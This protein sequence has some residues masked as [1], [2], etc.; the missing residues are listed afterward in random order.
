[1][2]QAKYLI[3]STLFIL[4][5]CGY[6]QTTTALSSAPIS[7]ALVKNDENGL[8]RGQLAQKMGETNKFR[9]SSS[10]NAKYELLIDVSGDRIETVGH[11]KGVGKSLGKLVP[12]EGNRFITAKVKVL[13][14][15]SGKEVVAPFVVTASVDF[16]FITPSSEEDIY[17]KI[18]NG[19]KI[20]T[21]KYSYGQL[22]AKET[23]EK[24]CQEPLFDRLSSQI[25]SALSRANINA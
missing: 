13:E 24:E 23:A 12:T 16:D 22:D 18:P 21:L 4:T 3:I 8:L 1:M 15:A 5:G 9:Y 14:K 6:Q 20:E 25:V 2:K 10:S 19:K 11:S 7:I 17:W